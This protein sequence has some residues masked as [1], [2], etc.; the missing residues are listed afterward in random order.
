MNTNENTIIENPC[1]NGYCTKC[2]RN[3]CGK[4]AANDRMYCDWID[5]CSDFSDSMFVNKQEKITYII[6]CIMILV[7]I[8]AAF[9]V[10]VTIGLVSD[11]GLYLMSAL[12]VVV[13]VCFIYICA[14]GFARG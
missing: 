5:E 7:A 9:V 6:C 12:S 2:N 14:V 10:F 3:I 1:S 8:I 11:I 13:S 4:C